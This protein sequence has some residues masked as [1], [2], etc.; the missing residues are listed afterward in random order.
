MN[1]TAKNII[2]LIE[3]SRPDDFSYGLLK[4]RVENLS[5]DELSSLL[6]RTMEVCTQ[7][8]SLR[9]APKNDIGIVASYQFIRD[10]NKG[11]L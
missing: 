3:N 6:E 4:D 5:D 1:D 11:Q 2:D 9:V 8:S 7:W 10:I